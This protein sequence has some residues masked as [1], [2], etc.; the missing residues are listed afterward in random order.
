MLSIEPRQRFTGFSATGADA[1]RFFGRFA[2]RELQD[3][4]LN[5]KLAKLGQEILELNW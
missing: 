5:L 4:A 2:G 3:G 1:L